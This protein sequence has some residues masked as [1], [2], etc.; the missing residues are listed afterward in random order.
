MRKFLTIGELSKKEDET[1]KY[2]HSSVESLFSTFYTNL[3][4]LYNFYAGKGK[5]EGEKLPFSIGVKNMSDFF[6]EFE[7]GQYNEDKPTIGLIMENHDNLRSVSRYGSCMKVP[8]AQKS[9]EENGEWKIF[10]HCPSDPNHLV[11]NYHSPYNYVFPRA[12][13]LALFKFF[14]QGFP[15][16][17]NGQEIGMDNYPF[18]YGEERQTF[19]HAGGFLKSVDLQMRAAMDRDFL[20]VQPDPNA[21]YWIEPRWMPKYWIDYQ[22]E[23]GRESAR[24]PFQ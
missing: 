14:Q 20:K 24:T 5:R 21:E 16:I 13:A 4:T 11:D 9:L 8:D 19:L 22:G 10:K 1:G 3:G 6:P 15:I 18:N 2:T 7:A 12:K 23:V 17:Y